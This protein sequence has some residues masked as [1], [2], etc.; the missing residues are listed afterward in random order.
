MENI[1]DKQK[2]K[3]ASGMIIISDNI[4]ISSKKKISD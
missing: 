2:V 1:I 3:R 4:D